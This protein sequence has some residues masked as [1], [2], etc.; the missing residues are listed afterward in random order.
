MPA[1]DRRGFLFRGVA[2][3]A[4]ALAAPGWAAAGAPSFLTAANRADNST[5]LVGLAGDGV[6]IGGESRAAGPAAEPPPRTKS[7]EA[8]RR[9]AGPAARNLPTAG[10]CRGIKEK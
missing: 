9:A 7:A 3:A 1:M 2:T 4:A 8:A 5:W 10:A 6:Q